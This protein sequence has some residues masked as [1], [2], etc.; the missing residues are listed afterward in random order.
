MR[1]RGRIVAEATGRGPWNEETLNYDDP[2]PTVIYEGKCKLT[3]GAVDPR[4][5]V[6]ADQSFAEV[7]GVLKLPVDGTAGV[8]R[9]QL[10][11]VLESGTDPGMVGLKLRIGARRLRSTPTSR[12]F[13]VEE[14]Q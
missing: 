5:Q 9:G 12:R 8:L 13:L 10:F 14:T 6:T 1:D 2:E 11:E 4:E 7:A 3:F